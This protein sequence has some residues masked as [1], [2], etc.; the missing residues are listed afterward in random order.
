M[1]KN[2]NLH[3]NIKLQTLNQTSKMYI[4]LDFTANFTHIIT[5]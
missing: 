5:L 2:N 3:K 1:L 4:T